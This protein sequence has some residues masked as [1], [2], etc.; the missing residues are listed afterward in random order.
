[1]KLL[2]LFC[3][4]GGLVAGLMGGE[5]SAVSAPGIQSQ[6]TEYP[7][8]VKVGL[9]IRKQGGSDSTWLFA[10]RGAELAVFKANENGGYDGRPFKLIVRSING[11]WGSGSR[12]IVKLV[13]ED[14]V[15][16]ILSSL[17]GRSAHLAE[18]IA[19]K[20]RVVLVSS[21]AT[22]PTLTQINIPWFFRCVPDDR[23]QATALIKEI[24]QVKQLKQVA[25]VADETYDARMA[26]DSF[27]GI[28]TSE[29]Y[30]APQRFSYGASGDDF[31]KV[32][33]E[34]G[35]TPV[36]GVVLFGRPSPAVKFIRKMW[37]RGMEQPLLGPLSLIAGNELLN[38]VGPELGNAVFVVS[39]YQNTPAGKGFEREFQAVY[40]SS[41]DAIAAYAYDGMSLILEAIRRGGLT[42]GRIREALAGIEYSRGV[43]GPIRFDDKGNRMGTVNLMRVIKGRPSVE[44]A[45]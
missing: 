30:Q 18:Q 1:M 34:I 4:S 8:V 17:D 5:P 40:G 20:G 21:R 3:L 13:F 24:Y 35:Q 7:K 32:L 39:G 9:L 23:Q 43:T 22:D 26:A 41:P 44:T 6:D 33:D 36:E 29:G 38:S 12:E 28:A 31:Q 10:K 25:T 2:R 16:A 14:S 37:A 11:L 42:K 45:E 15:R 19:T 27:I